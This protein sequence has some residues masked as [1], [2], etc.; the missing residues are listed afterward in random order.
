MIRWS[1]GQP[2]WKPRPKCWWSWCRSISK[3]LS[4]LRPA[5]ATPGF[6]SPMDRFRPWS[7]V[8]WTRASRWL[9]EN[10]RDFEWSMLAGW[11]KRWTSMLDVRW[12]S[13]PR[14]WGDV[15]MIS[16]P[17]MDDEI[18]VGIRMKYLSVSFF[19]KGFRCAIKINSD[20]WGNWSCTIK[21]FRRKWHFF[22]LG[23]V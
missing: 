20:L 23:S 6:S 19:F 9:R 3:W 7:M 22:W 14:T 13:W 8:R 16:F 1:P 2:K 17:M 10:G 21:N 15:T 4:A 18:V 12:S 11:Q 5:P